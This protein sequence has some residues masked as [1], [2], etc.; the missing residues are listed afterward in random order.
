MIKLLIRQALDLSVLGEYDMQPQTITGDKLN[1]FTFITASV[2][3]LAGILFGFDTGVISGAILFIAQEFNLSPAM[4]GL[5][6]SS[7]LFG[8][9]IGSG[10]S[11]RFSDAFGRKKLL[12]VTAIIFLTGTLGSA[13]APNLFFL[14]T[15]RIIVGIAIGI[16]S[17][18][19][20]LYISEIAPPKYRGALV[21]LN[22]LAI[23]VGILVSYLTDYALSDDEG[24]RLMLGI[25]VIPALGLL[26]G[27]CF[28][29][30]SPRWLLLKG[31]TE[32][33]KEIL[34]Y[35]RN[36]P[37]VDAEFNEIQKTV[38]QETLSSKK[39]WTVLLQKWVRPAIIVGFGLAFFQQVTGIN[40][41]IYYAPTIFKMAGFESA[42]TAILAT[43]GV[44]IV[45]VIFTIIALPLI[46]KLG[47]RPLLLIGLTG[48][49]F[50][51]G[52]LSIAFLHGTQDLGILK[53]FA[54]GSMVLYIACFAISLGPIMWLMFSEVF[55]LSIR[56]LGASVA[57]SFQWGL[58]MLVALTFLT[59][60]Q[61]LTP[62][63]TFLLFA[64]ISV[65]GI[66]FVYYTV[67]ET[68]GISL[69]EIEANLVAGKKSRDLGQRIDI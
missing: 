67:P 29:P 5:V 52:I 28:L 58:N 17:F 23:T 18:T 40:T 46:D 61:L 57:A 63:G 19:A 35:V 66:F 30:E 8:A 55:P 2:A 54:L 62:G 14:V 65:A 50:A 56:G 43:M 31:Y 48:M 51:L 59:L 64:A 27:M 3:G 7:V 22:Q 44:G 20:P 15:T 21:S 41:I 13:L 42:S 24:W 11:G 36:E 10:L 47:R 45:N 12:I 26:I 6:V 34:K 69:E 1:F 4:N 60:I 39:K 38:K 68:K 16:A 25:G 32:K 33:A 37:N 49:T 53:W 9:L